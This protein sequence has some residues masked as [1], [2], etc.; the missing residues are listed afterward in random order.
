MQ[1]DG[2]FAMKT[3]NPMAWL[4]EKIQQIRAVSPSANPYTPA[5][6]QYDMTEFAAYTSK[7]GQK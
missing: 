6:W 4:G 5:S 3:L 1:R 7:Q 2:G